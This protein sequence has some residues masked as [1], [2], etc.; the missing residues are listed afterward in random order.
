MTYRCAA[1]PFV[2]F[3]APAQGAGAAFE[4]KHDRLFR[5][6]DAAQDSDKFRIAPLGRSSSAVQ[7]LPGVVPNFSLS[8]LTHLTVQLRVAIAALDRVDSTIRFFLFRTKRIPACCR[9]VHD[10]LLRA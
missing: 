8:T 7:Q 4:P 3:F 10:A 2:C 1:G 6:V 9:A 5:S